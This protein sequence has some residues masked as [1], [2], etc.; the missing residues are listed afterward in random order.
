MLGDSTRLRLCAHAERRTCKDKLKAC[1][2]KFHFSPLIFTLRSYTPDELGLDSSLQKESFENL[3]VYAV[4][5]LG[6][7]A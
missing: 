2:S 6:Y 3:T 5:G 1:I 7:L 4:L